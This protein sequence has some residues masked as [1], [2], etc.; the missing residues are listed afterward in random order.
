MIFPQSILARAGLV[1]GGAVVLSAGGFAVGH[2]RGFVSGRAAGDARV[3]AL[4]QQLQAIE[5]QQTQQARA[6]EHV[7]AAAAANISA[8]YEKGKQDAQADADRIIAD[9]RAGNLKLREQWRGAGASASGVPSAAATAGQ[10]D[11]TERGREAGAARI[12]RAA[13]IC[14][15]QVA[16]L[17]AL[18]RSYVKL[19][20]GQQ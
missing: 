13:S 9:L 17:Q 2:H 11:A 1:L 16:G 3:A 6:A 19:T 8:S 4:T 15:A 14:D 18:V 20:G 10:P 12:V 7:Q 5:A